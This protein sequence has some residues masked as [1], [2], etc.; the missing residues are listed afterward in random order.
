MSNH[1][2][3]SISFQRE[4][5]KRNLAMDSEINKA[6]QELNFRSLLGQSRIRKQKGYGAITIL[7][8]IVLLPFLKKS[9]TA[10]WS[11]EK[12][13]PIHCRSKRHFLPVSQS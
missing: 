1:R 6:L 7:F 5:T 10:Y 11:E 9:M 4:L 13:G 2:S 3:F 12:L 8:Y